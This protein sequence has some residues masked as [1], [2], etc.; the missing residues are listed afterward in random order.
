MKKILALLIVF[1][2]WKIKRFLLIRIWKYEIDPSARIGLAYVYPKK[3]KM[4]EGSK[5]AHFNIAIHLDSIILGKN[6]SINRSNWITGFP[7]N[8]KSEHFQHQKDRESELVLKEEASIT[9]KHHIDCTNKIIIGKYT[10]VAGYCTQMLTHSVNIK[11]NIQDSYP[12]TIGDYCFIGTNCVILGGASL[13]SYSV[14]GAKSML[15]KKF[16]EDYHL[17]GG[18]PAGLIQPIGEDA[19]YFHRKSRYII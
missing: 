2:P 11:K 12:I 14:L 3:L 15:N 5:I 17:Y 8:S 13:P 1:L 4:A 10:I 7:I 18:N 9:K 6:A 19:K 16:T